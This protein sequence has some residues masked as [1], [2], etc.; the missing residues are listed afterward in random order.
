MVLSSVEILLALSVS[1]TD[2]CENLC[3]CQAFS[4]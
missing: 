1:M 2:L 3:F 4:R